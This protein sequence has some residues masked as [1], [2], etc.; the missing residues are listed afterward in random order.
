MCSHY[1]TLKDTELLLKKFGLREKPAAIGKY[2]LWPRY[3]RVFVKGPAEH[4]A[5]NEAMPDREAVHGQRA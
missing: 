4:D 3:Q 5:G 2:D 1:Q